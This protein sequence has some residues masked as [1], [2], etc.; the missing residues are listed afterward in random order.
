MRGPV[1][2]QGGQAPGPGPRSPRGYLHA[3]GGHAAPRISGAN[4]PG[5]FAL[6]RCELPALSQVFSLGRGGAAG[7]GAGRGG[8]GRGGGRE[9][10]Q[11]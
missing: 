11:N 1:L 6:L 9:R 10:G 5:S 7:D 3:E 8:R 2:P 4:P